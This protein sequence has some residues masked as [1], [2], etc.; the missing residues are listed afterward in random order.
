MNKYDIAIEIERQFLGC[1]LIDPTLL[2]ET[3][4]KSEHF[5]E[6]HNR[7]LFKAMQE[8]KQTGEEVSL[9]SLVQLGKSRTILFGGRSYLT[10]LRA[11]VPS[12][13][14]FKSYEKSIINFRS[15]QTAIDYANAFINDTKET[16][17]MQQLSGFIQNISKLEADTVAESLDFKQKVSNRIKQHKE[18]PDK[19]LSGTSTGFMNLNLITDGWQQGDLIIIG[20]RPSMGKTAFALNSILNACKSEKVKG[21]IFSIEMT[22]ESIIDRLIATEGQINLMKLRNPNRRF[23]EKDWEKYKKATES[24]K[25]LDIDIRPNDNTVPN[26]RAVVRK[27]IKENPDRKH[28]VVIDF[29][30]L[31]KSTETQQSRHQEVEEIVLDLKQMAKELKVPV[32]VIAQL[33][34]SGVRP[35]YM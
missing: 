18:S 3:I 29:L 4:L 21:T 7:E 35:R 34:R 17:K 30:T 28:V 15:I 23:D 16:H 31:I 26:M 25:N 22:E 19:G 8:I 2:E 32:I 1:I 9:I 27:N 5:I 6:Q 14:S 20:A 12:V 33:S 24:L 13:H 10:K 11:S